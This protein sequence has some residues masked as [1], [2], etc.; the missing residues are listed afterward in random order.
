[1][2]RRAKTGVTY[3]NLHIFHTLH[4]LLRKRR[5]SANMGGKLRCKDYL[6]VLGLW[7]LPLNLAIS[8]LTCRWWLARWFS[9][10]GKGR[11]WTLTLLSCQLENWLDMGNLWNGGRSRGQFKGIVCSWRRLWWCRSVRFI[12]SFSLWKATIWS[13]GTKSILRQFLR[14]CQRQTLIMS[15]TCCSLFTRWHFKVG[16]N[17]TKLEATK[18]TRRLY[19]KFVIDQRGEYHAKWYG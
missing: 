18:L 8:E 13:F 11:D 14:N 15:D 1:M 6:D 19:C 2:C 9:C 4:Q 7:L 3:L 12:S 5:Q 17:S 16:S 10:V